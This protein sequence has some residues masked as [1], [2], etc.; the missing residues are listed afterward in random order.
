MSIHKRGIEDQLCSF[1]GDLQ[2]APLL[3]LAT[4]WFEASLN[5]IDAYSERVDQVE[6]L[7]MFRQDGRER[8]WDNVTKVWPRVSR[9]RVALLSMISAALAEAKGRVSG[10]ASAA[11]KLGIPPSTLESK[12]R[13]ININKYIFKTL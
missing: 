7:G 9:V 5:P 6:A 10:P 2:L 3:H 12:I 1:V 11:T 8:A 4:Q 13:S